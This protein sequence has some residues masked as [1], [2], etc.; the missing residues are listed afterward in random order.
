MYLLLHSSHTPAVVGLKLDAL[1]G[2]F[3]VLMSQTSQVS[4]FLYKP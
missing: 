4:T 1:V 2:R 3:F